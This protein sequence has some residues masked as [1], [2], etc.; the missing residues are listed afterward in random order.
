VLT[1][2]D[3]ERT[4][5]EKG[6]QWLLKSM[7]AQ[8]KC[9]NKHNVAIEKHMFFWRR[10]SH[11]CLVN[12]TWHQRPRELKTINERL[13]VLEGTTISKFMGNEQSI[14]NFQET[15][16]SRLMVLHETVI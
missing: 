15:T 2:K 8:T 7:T 13:K 11:W 6:E 3:V 14:Y 10:E 5:K 12:E 4:Q 9:R 1:Y 16:I